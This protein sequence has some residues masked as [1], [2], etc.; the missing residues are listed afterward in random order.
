MPR[1]ILAPAAE[2]DIFS[3][4]AWTHEHFSEQGRVKYESLLVQAIEDVAENPEPPGSV[5]REGLIVG[6]RT[7]HLRYSREHVDQAMGIVRKPRHFLVFRLN[8][9]GEVEIGRVLHDS[10]DFLSKLPDD[11]LDTTP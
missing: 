4:L 7:Y 9:R 10:M 3:I 1:Y 8:T 5:N 6:G 11:C 2:E